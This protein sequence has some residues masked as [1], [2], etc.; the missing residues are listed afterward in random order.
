LGLTAVNKVN[1]ELKA[2]EILGLD[3]P[4]GAGKST[5]FNL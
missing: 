1:F 2:G 4:N 3:R 5:M